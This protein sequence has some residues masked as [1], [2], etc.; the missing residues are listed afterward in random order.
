MQFPATPRRQ[1]AGK[2]EFY[3]GMRARDNHT[4]DDWKMVYSKYTKRRILFYEADRLSVG[5]IVKAL[6]KEGIDS[7]KAGVWK[8]LQK[9]KE[10]GDISRKP[11][12]GRRRKVWK[13]C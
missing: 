2:H 13:N 4:Q 8:F 12:S 9:V 6:K 1:S 11:G 7:S 3:T 10:N 5:Q